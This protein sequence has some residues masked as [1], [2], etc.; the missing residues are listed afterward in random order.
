[1]SLESFGFGAG[2]GLIAGV[3][4]AVLTAFGLRERIRCLEDTKLSKDVFEE[5]RKGVIDALKVITDKVNH[6]DSK[7]DLLLKK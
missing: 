7:L 4:G 5:Y 1:V 2:G 3:L 6:I